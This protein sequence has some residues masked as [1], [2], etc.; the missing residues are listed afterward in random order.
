LGTGPEP[1]LP[2]KE[3]FYP[4]DNSGQEFEIVPQPALNELGGDFGLGFF[5]RVAER[6]P[7]N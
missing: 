1:G 7:A 6:D 4:A 3:W 5:L 2:I